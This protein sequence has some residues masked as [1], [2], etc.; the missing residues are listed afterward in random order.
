MSRAKKESTKKGACEKMPRPN[1]ATTHK[2]PAK[3]DATKK[4]PAKPAADKAAAPAA[5][6]ADSKN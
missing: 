5:P 3:T 4:A 1:P 6:A 2:A